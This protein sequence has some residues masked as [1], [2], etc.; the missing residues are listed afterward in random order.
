MLE[1]IDVQTVRRHLARARERV[2][3][4]QPYSPA[5]DAAM[6]GVEDLER[7][8]SHQVQKTTTGRQPGRTGA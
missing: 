2:A 6:A 5:W 7:E 8:V 1:T 3:E 4:L